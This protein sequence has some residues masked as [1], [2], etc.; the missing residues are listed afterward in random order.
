MTG[1]VVRG[2][3]QSSKM[4]S[5]EFAFFDDGLLELAH[6]G[7]LTTIL[8][9]VLRWYISIMKQERWSRIYAELT[10]LC[11]SS[12]CTAAGDH[13]YRPSPQDDG[14]M[15]FLSPV[16]SY[17]SSHFALDYCATSCHSKDSGTK[18]GRVPQDLVIIQLQHTP[19]LPTVLVPHWDE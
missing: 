8:A 6:F 18:E 13:H 5:I 12:G 16:G 10:L 3:V 2:W 17:N 7:I 1:I 15:V 9:T 4:H 11:G 19:Y 14:N